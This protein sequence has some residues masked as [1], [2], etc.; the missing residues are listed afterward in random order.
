MAGNSFIIGG[1]I[2]RAGGLVILQGAR[3]PF[4]P[5]DSTVSL[6]VS[7]SKTLMRCPRSAEISLLTHMK[8]ILLLCK[9]IIIPIGVTVV[10]NASINT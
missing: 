9:G 10:I 1:R 6:T 2:G 7:A 5:Y 3:N 8:G 4:L